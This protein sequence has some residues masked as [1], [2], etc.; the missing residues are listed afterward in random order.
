MQ[1]STKREKTQKN[2]KWKK[3][4]YHD[5]V[6]RAGQYSEQPGSG[7]FSLLTQITS[8]TKNVCAKVLKFFFHLGMA[9][10]HHN[11]I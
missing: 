5:T 11:R 2:R 1:N 7:T 6:N 4:H 8:Y 10:N 9:T 3:N